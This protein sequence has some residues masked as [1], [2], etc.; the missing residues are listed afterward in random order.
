MVNT[1][2]KFSSDNI[3]SLSQVAVTAYVSGTDMLLGFW[4]K[5]KLIEVRNL[6]LEDSQ[7]I[8]TALDGL[9]VN[10]LNVVYDNHLFAHSDFDSFNPLNFNQYFSD[11]ALR[12]TKDS[13]SS[14]YEKLKQQKVF[15]LSFIDQLISQSAEAL[16]KK[17]KLHH[18]STAMA[19]YSLNK[20][21]Q[22]LV[23]IGDETL[24]VLVHK[25]GFKGYTQ[26]N[27]EHAQD[28]LYYIL[29]AAQNNGM[30]ITK[31]PVYI[32]G[33]IDIS[34]PLY[35]TLKSHIYNLNF[36]GDDHYACANVDCPIHYYLPL[37]IARACA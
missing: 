4:D 37:M 11:Q 17:T 5:K 2:V 28:Y 18:V 14:S 24:S 1:S 34:S 23:L 26:Y 29:L 25:D 6:N 3:S 20:K 33:N 12:S 30:D 10:E 16:H 31:V 9:E 36:T 27:L 15:T 19:N 32:G 13:A 8:S 7:S 22:I 21:D 35:G